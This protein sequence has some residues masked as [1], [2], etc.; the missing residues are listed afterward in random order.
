MFKHLL[1]PTDGSEFSMTVIRRAVSFAGDV[2]ARITFLFVEHAFPAIYVGEGAIMDEHAGVDFIEQ[3]N[4]QANQ[5]LAM[6][7]NIAH[8]AGVECSLLALICEV[9][10]EAIIEAAQRNECDL[11]FMASHGENSIGQR[12]LS[13][14]T[15]KVLS[16]ST[17]PVLAYR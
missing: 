6:A 10:Y 16:H 14:E 8:A 12:L 2:G 15:E 17:I 9:P 4:R 5:A 7:E 11:I 13:S 3:A 1:F